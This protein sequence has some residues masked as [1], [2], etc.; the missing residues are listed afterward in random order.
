M[1]TKAIKSKIKGIG[2]IKKITRTMEMVSV[3]KMKKAAGLAEAYK[4]FALEASR[5]LS[6]LGDQRATHALSL[7]NDSKRKLII[8]IAGE[9]GLC[10]SYNSNIYRHVYKK[11][12]DQNEN[13]DFITIGKYSDKIARKFI[14]KKGDNIKM[15][16][17]G[18]EFSSVESSI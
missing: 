12:K 5:L 17:A 13:M 4:P 18:K 3:A 15:S 11:Y 10:G 8:L 6:I 1:Q 14:N 16:F 9:K 7:H 2:N